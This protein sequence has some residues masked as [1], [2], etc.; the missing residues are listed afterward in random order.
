MFVLPLFL[1]SFPPTALIGKLRRAMYPAMKTRQ[2]S[3]DGERRQARALA[4]QR[5]LLPALA[6]PARYFIGPGADVRCA[7]GCRPSPPCSVD[8]RTVSR[9]ARLVPHRLRLAASAQAAHRHPEPARGAACW[10]ASLGIGLADRWRGCACSVAG[11]GISRRGAVLIGVAAGIVAGM[12]AGLFPPAAVLLGFGA[13]AGAR[14]L[15]DDMPVEEAPPPPPPPVDHAHRRWR[16]RRAGWPHCVPGWAPARRSRWTS[17]ARRW[18]PWRACCV[19]SRAAPITSPRRVASWRCSWT[20]WTVSLLRL[21]R[22]AEPPATLVPL[23]DGIA[24]AADDWRQRHR[25][26][27]SAALDIQ[28]KV[29]G[30]R[31]R[32]DGR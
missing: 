3:A 26:A 22:G 1:A 25:A 31:L 7:C 30:D 17:S 12:G 5:P 32:E 14:L 21:E 16:R 24:D 2:I 11:P 15:S 27:E 9:P 20:G 4:L 13:W 23:L 29:M 19:R 8:D 10:P 6:L 18:R 28:V